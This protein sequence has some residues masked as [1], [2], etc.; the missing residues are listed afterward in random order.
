MSRGCCVGRA[1]S[2]GRSNCVIGAMLTRFERCIF[3]GCYL[4][5]V[6]RPLA[7]LVSY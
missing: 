1:S 2:G 5:M 7:G 4:G 3:L 6:V